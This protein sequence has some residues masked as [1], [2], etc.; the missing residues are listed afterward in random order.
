MPL[1]INF[2]QR[3]TCNNQSTKFWITI[4]IISTVSQSYTT[5]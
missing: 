4:N 3:K 2:W 5:G 1:L